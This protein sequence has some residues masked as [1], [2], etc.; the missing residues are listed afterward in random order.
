MTIVSRPST[1]STRKFSHGIFVER[2]RDYEHI[3][4]AVVITLTPRDRAENSGKNNGRLPRVNVLCDSFEQGATQLC[5]FDDGATR[6]MITVQQVPTG[7]DLHDSAV[8]QSQQCL[9]DA[10][11]RR[12]TRESMNLPESERRRGAG[13]HLKNDTLESTCHAH[14]RVCGFHT[15]P[16]TIVHIMHYCAHPI[17]RGHAA[18]VGGYLMA[19]PPSIGVTCGTS[20]CG[21]LRYFA[22]TA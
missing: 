22:F 21:R 16:C 14:Q 19:G 9:A 15:P 6:E 4:V 7:N 3:D 13:E 2:I 10:A 5:E 17:R 12:G 11:L 20:I 8:D 1:N 18:D